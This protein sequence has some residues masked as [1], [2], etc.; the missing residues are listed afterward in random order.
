M[1]VTITAS[2]KGSL[3]L[4]TPVMNAAGVFGYGDE[5]RDLVQIDKLGAIVTNPVTYAAW[6]PASGTRVIP[7]D[8]GVLVHTGLPNPGVSKVISAHRNL[9]SRLPVPLI[10]HIIP[11]NADD[12]RRFAERIDEEECIAGIEVG[13]NDEVSVVEAARQI[14]ALVESTEK[15][16]LARLPFGVGADYARSIVD[17]GAGG[18]VVSA[19]PR[20]T[21]RDSGG[22][23]VSGR[24]YGA[25]VKPMTL[26]LVGYLARRVDIPV[27]GAG[28]IHTP[29]DA[30]D[31]LEAGAVAVQVDSV[32]WINPKAIEL[33]A[34]DL[35]GLVVTQPTGALPDE[36]YPGMG[37]TALQRRIDAPSEDTP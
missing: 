25:L 11:L 6:N 27:I 35:G 34:R 31:Y 32:V 13:I 16:V 21:A 17:A 30:R 7:L 12:S 15:P 18:L 9:W 36:W 37:E 4:N 24:L 22:R 20:G 8:A 23:L 5:Y 19:P 3:T 14:K 2:S 29:E 10:L 33:I 1:T 28:G 26:R